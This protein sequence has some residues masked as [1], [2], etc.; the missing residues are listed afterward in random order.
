MNGVSISAW[1]TKIPS[2]NL[3][4]AVENTGGTVYYSNSLSRKNIFP[5]KTNSFLVKIFYPDTVYSSGY[6]S[7]NMLSTI[8]DF[9]MISYRGWLPVWP[10]L[11]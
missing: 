5:L 9:G 8:A 1:V 7:K 2:D 11:L 10:D 4:L 6:P 3:I